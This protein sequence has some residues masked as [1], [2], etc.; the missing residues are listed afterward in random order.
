MD[1]TLR[2]IRDAVE[3]HRAA[4]RAAPASVA[5]L[6]HARL[7]K[8]LAAESGET[9]RTL[10]RLA[11][12]APNT[13]PCAKERADETY[14]QI[15]RSANSVVEQVSAVER[16]DLFLAISEAMRAQRY[17]DESA[18]L[19][20]L[21]SMKIDLAPYFNAE[22]GAL[23]LTLEPGRSTTTHLATLMR[24]V[25]RNSDEFK[26]HDLVNGTIVKCCIEMA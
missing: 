2:A 12:R 13:P 7:A 15:A 1:A 20:L 26:V 21:D 3:R 6:E 22:K 14:E 17:L 9:A 10:T 18:L 8:L 23:T 19:V 25:L 16:R 11:K 5:A 24:V 4:I